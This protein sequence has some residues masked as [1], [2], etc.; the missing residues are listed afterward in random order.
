[1]KGSASTSAYAHGRHDGGKR[2]YRSHEER[3]HDLYDPDSDAVS[4]EY[5]IPRAELVFTDNPEDER[6][7]AAPR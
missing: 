4:I 5:S 2:R 7:A 1:M 6:L 3:R